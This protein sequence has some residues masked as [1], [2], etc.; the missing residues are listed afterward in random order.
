[1]SFIRIR[2]CIMYSFLE[3]NDSSNKNR[4]NLMSTSSLYI[5]L[6]CITE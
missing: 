5:N 6:T 4:Y 1:M 2:L 3:S